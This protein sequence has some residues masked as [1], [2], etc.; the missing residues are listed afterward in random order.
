LVDYCL[1]S[2]GGWWV[3]VETFLVGVL[4]NVLQSHDLFP[5]KT[6]FFDV[7][8]DDL[9]H[10]ESYCLELVIFDQTITDEFVSSEKKSFLDKIRTLGKALIMKVESLHTSSFLL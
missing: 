9:I 3:F 8:L 4:D 5:K 2:V 10:N 6:H 1:L 7:W